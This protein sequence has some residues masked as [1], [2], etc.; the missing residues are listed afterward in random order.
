MRFYPFGSGS[1][2]S[3]VESAVR[4]L[5]AEKASSTLRTIS[6]SI[7]LTS[8]KG[9]PGENGVASTFHGPYSSYP[10]E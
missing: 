3:Y 1:K 7:A 5:Y 6:S 9:P 2:V 8:S 10:P 4:A